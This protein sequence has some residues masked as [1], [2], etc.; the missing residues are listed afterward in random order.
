MQQKMIHICLFFSFGLIDVKHVFVIYLLKTG[1]ID[2]YL[3]RMGKARSMN[4]KKKCDDA[5]SKNTIKTCDNNSGM[6]RPWP[7]LTHDVLN[8]VMIKLEVVDFVAFSRV[9]KSWRSLAVSN[10]NKFLVSKP[11]MSISITSNDAYEIEYDLNDFT[12]RKLK[13][14]VPHLANRL[15]VG[16]TC[17]YLILFHAKRNDFWLVN[18]ITRHE[19]H[20]P[21]YKVPH[22]K[23]HC[24][25]REYFKGVLVFSRSISEWVFVICKGSH[26][27]WF[28]V[29]G[30]R[31]WNYFSSTTRSTINDLIAF[32][33]KIY[34]LHEEPDEV[35]LCEMKLYPKP[36]L[37][38][39][40]S[41]PEP[42]FSNPEFVSSVENLYVINQYAHY[43]Y[44]IHELDVDEM[45][46]VKCD[47]IGEKY[48]F[49]RSGFPY[50][51]KTF[52]LREAWADIHSQYGK[53]AVDD[54][55]MTYCASMWYFFDDCLNVNLIQ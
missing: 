6:A 52:T 18:P 21:N 51:N 40:M 37:V 48:A 43:P 53:Y 35:E 30:K 45:K 1:L 19:L 33:G 29:A 27:I 50:W 38:L 5:M 10:R 7:D 13:T 28:C 54:K 31:E 32:K 8:L 9:C 22:F 34:T 20:F 46:W 39:L 3:F 47:K 4:R 23:F 41:N 42:N 17:G 2:I 36:E 12:G 11:P 26:M 14:F 16:V 25:I 24:S 44:N 55:N 49:F 15:C